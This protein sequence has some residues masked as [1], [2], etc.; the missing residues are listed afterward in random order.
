ITGHCLWV[1]LHRHYDWSPG[2]LHGEGV[3]EDD[4]PKSVSETRCCPCARLPKEDAMTTTPVPS[5]KGNYSGWSASPHVTD[6]PM[7]TLLLIDDDGMDRTYYADRL[8]IFIP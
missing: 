7:T 8:K 3:W 5:V 2:N 6:P 1:Y 4:C